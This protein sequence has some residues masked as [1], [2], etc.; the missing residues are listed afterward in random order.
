MKKYLLI[1]ASCIY[2]SANSQT[3][4]AFVTNNGMGTIPAFTLGKPAGLVYMKGN[5]T[6]HL[7]FAPNITF[8]LKNLK[9]W[10]L[11]AWLKWN[12][13][14]D[15]QKKWTATAGVDWSLIFR[16]VKIAG[17]EETISESVRYPMVEGKLQFLPDEKTS[18]VFDYQYGWTMGNE[19]KDGGHYYSLQYS[20]DVDVKKFLLSNSLNMFYVDYCYD[21]KGFDVFFETAMEHKK[22]GLFI[23]AQIIQP[24]T[25]KQTDFDYGITLGIRCKLK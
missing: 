24:I 10:F 3:I 5:I 4:K 15:K 8:S 13:P 21:A 16:D 25:V 17:G 7:E 20:K 19:Y 2:I 1:L 18:F 9:G 23:G 14:L 11:D 12:Q 22:T 6:N